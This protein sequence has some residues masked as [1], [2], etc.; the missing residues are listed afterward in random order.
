MT[1]RV[2]KLA[3]QHYYRWRATQATDSEITEA[4]RAN[5]LFD[6]HR[7][8]PE[9]GYR[10]LVEEACAAGESVA[11]RTAWRICSTHR[12]WSVRSTRSSSTG[13]PTLPFLPRVLPNTTSPPKDQISCG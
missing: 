8:N 4:Y 5:A 2:L 11:E 7:E 3:R 13:G 10:Y 9:F 6:A 1:C 12:L